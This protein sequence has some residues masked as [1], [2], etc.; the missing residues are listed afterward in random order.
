MLH[1]LLSRF[2]EVCGAPGASLSRDWGGV[3]GRELQSTFGTRNML[4][5]YLAFLWQD[6]LYLMSNELVWRFEGTG[7]YSVKS[8]YRLSHASSIT[9]GSGPAINQVGVTPAPHWVRTFVSSL[10]SEWY[11]AGV[12]SNGVA[13][14]LAKEGRSL[15][16][17]SYWIEEAPLAVVSL[18]ESERRQLSLVD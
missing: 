14:L 7:V 18:A 3:L 4:N 13:H 10:L 5:E 9:H 17:P 1:C 11:M 8:G 2:G 16:S 6:M 12:E 15:V